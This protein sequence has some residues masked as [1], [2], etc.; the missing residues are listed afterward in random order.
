MHRIGHCIGEDYSQPT[1]GEDSKRYHIV[2]ERFFYLDGAIVVVSGYSPLAV[3]NVSQPNAKCHNERYVPLGS[4][5][6]CPYSRE[7]CRTGKYLVISTEQYLQ[8]L[9]YW[10]FNTASSLVS[11]TTRIYSSIPYEG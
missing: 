11:V 7:R 10:R 8:V 2:Y 5:V 1:L 6:T 4:M 3:G 9:I